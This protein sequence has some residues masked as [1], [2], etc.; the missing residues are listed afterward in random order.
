MAAQQDT[1]D[2]TWVLDRP[3]PEC[4]FRSGTPHA[5][6]A[7]RIDANVVRWQRVLTRPQI[8][9]RPSVPVWSPPE[10]ACH[11]RD[12]YAICR[13]RLDLMLNNDDPAFPNWNQD[14]TSNEGRYWAA[15]PGQTAPELSVAGGALADGFRAVR[16]DQWQRPGRRSNG[17]VFTVET[18]AWYGLH[19]DAHHLFDVNG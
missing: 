10:Y 8:G 3:C 5:E 13:L 11:V 7:A 4:G 14:A 12:V 1:K 15:D 19:D 16:A 6:I 2:W 17:S 18:L 9:Q